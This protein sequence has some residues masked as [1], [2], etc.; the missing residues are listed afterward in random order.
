ME[1]FNTL[2]R[3]QKPVIML[4]YIGE[5]HGLPQAANQ[6]DYTARM[7]EFFDHYLK[8]APA[9]EW[10]TKGVPRLQ[11]EDHLKERAKPKTPS[12]KI[13]TTDQPSRER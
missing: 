12:K 5:N 4:E 10:L 2:R 13:T 11:M 1:Y 6:R 8:G 7:L 3:L 9:P